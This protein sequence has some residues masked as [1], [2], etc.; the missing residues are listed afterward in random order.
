MT[1]QAPT[2][3]AIE[4]EYRRR[5]DERRRA[6]EHLEQRHAQ[7][8][9]ARLAIAAAGIIVFWR[10]G[11]DALAWLLVP[12]ALFAA[13]AF[14]H[15]RLL[16]RMDRARSAIHFYE[17][18][19]ARIRHEWIGHGRS[20]ERY[21]QTDHLYADDLDLF[22][23]GSLFELLSTT[24]TRAG[25]DVLAGWLLA[26]AAHT[27]ARAR[28]DA[29]RELASRLDLR[30]T[31]AVI[32]DHVKVAV[33]AP[34]LRQ[35]AAS[36][37]GI[38]SHALRVAVAGL[39]ATTLLTLVWWWQTGQLG[40]LAVVLL[41]A[42][43]AMATALRGRVVGVI[44]A[45]EAPAHDLDVLATLLRV[46]ERE[47]FE[48][49]HLRALQQSLAGTQT[50]SKEIDR[51]SRLVALLASRRNVMFAAPAGLLMWATQWAFAID[52]WKRRAGVHIP[53]WLDVV[54]EFEA[55]LAL[56]GFAAEHPGYVFPE[57]TD[58]PPAVAATELAHATLG[59]SAVANDLDLGG[60]EAPHLLV[61]SGSNMSGKST[62]MRTIGVTVVLA[63]MG[64]PVRAAACRLSPLAIG[65]AIRVQDSLTDGR[66]RF[67]AEILRL[68]HVVELAR[69]EQ[70]AVLFLLD[71][72]L[73]G[74]NSH[75]RRIGAEA[76]MVGLVRA[77]A[78]GLVTTHDLALARVTDDLGS[79]AVNAHFDDRF[80][81]GHLHFDYRLKPGVVETSNALA[82]MRSIG[83]E[84]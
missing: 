66:S 41:V 62:W 65:A 18:G 64:A 2:D 74:T 75:D 27:V 36:G 68:K 77:G 81:D 4:A 63:R 58:G 12:F 14:A 76:V 42:Q 31:V 79:R 5:L 56:G 11:L 21:R 57:L 67:F 53:H 45:V 59:P 13:V 46:I 9:Y 29:V 82:L 19:L 78:I 39:V 48:S 32:G 1:E 33:D 37:H 55:L 30:E 49:A 8:G 73:S 35:W 43:L 25:E 24:R 6:L 15:A 54:G 70:G 28:Q 84:V 44:E 20:G 34:L 40:A 52:A 69:R 22:G 7:F 3:S 83:I 17:R 51:L 23:R 60:A 38:A 72:I 26:P 71:E 50:A 47:S 10:G 16:N 80:I 61:V